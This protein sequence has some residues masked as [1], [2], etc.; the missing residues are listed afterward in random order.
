MVFE[1]RLEAIDMCHFICHS[2]SRSVRMTSQGTSEFLLLGD[3]KVKRFYTKI[4][5]SQAQN[6]DFVQARNMDEVRTALSAIKNTSKFIILAFLTNLVVN[7]GDSAQNDID[8]MSSIDEMFNS[9][10]PLIR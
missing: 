9:I 1:L 3:S 4:G 6:I 7:A 8:R 2:T 10:V 5:L